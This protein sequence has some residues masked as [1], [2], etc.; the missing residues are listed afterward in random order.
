VHSG[1]VR[2]LAS[3][4]QLRQQGGVLHVIMPAQREGVGAAL[5]VLTKDIHRFG[6]FAPS[7]ASGPMSLSVRRSRLD[8]TCAAVKA[9]VAATIARPG[10]EECQGQTEAG[11]DGVPPLVARENV[12]RAGGALT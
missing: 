11:A 4:A 10:L 8:V 9:V 6:A 5:V 12:L 7:P 3:L 1:R 2:G